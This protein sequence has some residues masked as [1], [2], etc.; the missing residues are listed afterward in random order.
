MKRCLAESGIEAT[1]QG[2]GLTIESTEAQSSQINA[3]VAACE[4]KFGY[5]TITSLSD[6]QLKELYEFERTTAAC[7]T[8]LGYRV[9]LPSEAVFIESYYSGEFALLESQLLSQAADQAAYEEAM[10]SCPPAAT[11]YDPYSG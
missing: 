6:S 11:Q 2:P 7:L 10:A 9:A 3:A 1:V 8:D 5:D 4:H